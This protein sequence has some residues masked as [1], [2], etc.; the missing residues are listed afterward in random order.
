[1]SGH[2]PLIP[3]PQPVTT[4][5]I[6]RAALRLLEA[7]ERDCRR[8]GVNVPTELQEWIEA[9]KITAAWR[10]SAVGS[11]VDEGAEA[12]AGSADATAAG[13]PDQHEAT[14]EEAGRRLGLSGRQ[15]RNLCDSG[16]LR[17]R[18]VGGIWLVDTAALEDHRVARAAG[19]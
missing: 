4:P 17:A 6:A 5:A 19:G 7:G 1:M 14:A 18:K 10:T 11:A 3:W 2:L 13:E 15:V 9:L 12:G 8:N 16:Q